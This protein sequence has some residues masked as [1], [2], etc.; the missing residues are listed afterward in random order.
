MFHR[1][2]D[3]FMAQSGDVKFGNSKNNNFD[4]NRAG[5]GGSNLPDLKQ[6]LITYLMKEGHCQWLDLLA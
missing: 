5:M 2:I 3:G 6:N 4:L 1:V